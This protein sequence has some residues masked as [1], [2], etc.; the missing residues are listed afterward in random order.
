MA[1][2]TPATRKRR[3]LG[4]AGKVNGLLDLEAMGGYGIVYQTRKQAR[5]YY[6][7]VVRVEVREVK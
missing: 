1:N 5:D 3:V 6:Q 7:H 2:S 4:W